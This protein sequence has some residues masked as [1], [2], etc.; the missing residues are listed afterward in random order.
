M[1]RTT[2]LTAAT[3]LGL[4][5]LAPTTSATAAAET[6]RGEAATLVGTGPTITGTEGRD[7][8][9]S[10][11]ATTVSGL[12]GDDLICVA[13]ARVSS[14]VLDVDAGAGNDTV[15]T[16][17][18]PNSYYVT[19]VLG[20]GADT[21]VGGASNDRVTTGDPATEGIDADRDDVRSGD[22]VDQVTTGISVPAGYPGDAPNRDVVDA[23]AADDRVT[24]VTWSMAPDGLVTGG[25]GRD[26]LVTTTVPVK[27][28]VF[29]DMTAGT[30]HG[31]A[32]HPLDYDG[33]QARFSSF[34][35][36]DLEVAGEVVTYRGTAGDDRLELTVKDICC[37]PTSLHADTL[38]GDDQLLLHNAILGSP[39]SIDMGLGRDQVVAGRDDG[40]LGLDL[41]RGALTA[42]NGAVTVA[43]IE[44]AFLMAPRVEMVGDNVEND[45][46]FNGCT[47]TI[48]G[49]HGDD[50][51]TN[52][53]GDPWWEEY[54]FD[55]RA[56]SRMFGGPGTDRIRGGQ[57]RD[58]LV[59]D[60][61][62]DRLEGRGGDD[63]LLGGRGRDAADGGKG[64]DRC[65]AE[66]E[67][68]C[69]V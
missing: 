34:E 12:G 9:V 63:V 67:L 1:R 68:R 33:V 18:A 21:F 45:L 13:P 3:L 25:E 65:V 4:A 31:I 62:R 57:G 32:N 53:A 28:E 20:A 43:G 24:L 49:G 52:V 37:V 26:T 7:V 64:G 35:G 47:A 51:L 2:S 66:R 23:G 46:L 44:D 16:A 38:D 61:D 42:G 59:G 10:G 54:E 69:E 40:R 58:R 22:G 14:N 60:G 6:C 30:L 5:L 11:K 55:C 19:V 27:A 8:I 36:L 39:S 15:D 41:K 29:A 56:S 17:G 48:V 50:Y